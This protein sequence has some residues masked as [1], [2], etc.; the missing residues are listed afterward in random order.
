[1]PGY[2][3]NLQKLQKHYTRLLEPVCKQW[4]LTRNE[5]DVLLFLHNNPSLNRATDIVTCRGIAKSHVSL[6]V[7]ALEKRGFLRRQTDPEDR[8]TVRLG[9]TKAAAPAVQQG[10]EAQN[11]FV[12]L[13]IDGL[14]TEELAAW[15]ALESKV[16][17]NIEKME[18]L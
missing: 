16:R 5:L 11:A 3:D 12:A 8:R 7:V 10:R 18:D 2:F 17:R 9:L 6:A 13:L 15:R 14:S 1:M 4:S